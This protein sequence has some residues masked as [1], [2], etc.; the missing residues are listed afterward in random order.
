[1]T[2]ANI[3]AN[4]NTIPMINSSNFKSWKENLEIV[5]GVMDLDLTLREDSP[6]ALTDKSTS[7]QNREKERWEKSN[8]MCVM[9]MKKSIP[10]PFR[11][12]ISETLTK[13]KDFLEHIEK[14]FV[15]NVP[16]KRG[17]A[18]FFEDVG[19]VGG[20]KVKDIIEEEYDDIPMGT[21]DIV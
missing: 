15:K 17:N 4:F 21:I 16:L 19:F 18:R 6:H 10:E 8:C 5:L 7:E 2:P 13:A 3:T 9:I 20:D 11:G 14:R 12:T 1:M